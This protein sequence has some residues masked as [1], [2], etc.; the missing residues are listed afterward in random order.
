MV[1]YNRQNPNDKA[2][3]SIIISNLRVRLDAI[4]ITNIILRV[5]GTR[6][7]IKEICRLVRDQVDGITIQISKEAAPK[8]KDLKNYWDLVIRGSYNKVT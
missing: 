7:I 6:R 3:R 1:L 8:G 2:I 4:I 5:L